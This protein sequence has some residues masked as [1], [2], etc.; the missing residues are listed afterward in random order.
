MAVPKKRKSKMKTRS[1]RSANLKLKM[2]HY[3][4]CSHCGAP[5]RRHRACHECGTYRDEQVIEVW[6]Y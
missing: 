1:R 6:E 3:Q 2:P 5:K 4:A